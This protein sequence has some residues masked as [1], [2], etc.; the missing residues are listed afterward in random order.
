MCVTGLQ[1]IENRRPN[2]LR[3]YT[4]H[5]TASTHER[6]RSAC[7]APLT[8]TQ[9]SARFSTPG[10][11]ALPRLVPEPVPSTPVRPRIP[12]RAARAKQA[13][14]AHS[15]GDQAADEHAGL[16]DIEVPAT[17]AARERSRGRSRF[18]GGPGLQQRRA[19]PPN[20]AWWAVVDICLRWRALSSHIVSR[21]RIVASTWSACSA[22]TV[23]SCVSASDISGSGGRSSSGAAGAAASAPRRAGDASP[24]A[25]HCRRASLSIATH[26][27]SAAS[28]WRSDS[29]SFAGST[30]VC[31]ARRP[32][33]CFLLQ[34][35]E[36]FPARG[37]R[38]EGG[39]GRRECDAPGRRPDDESRACTRKRPAVSPPPRR[40]SLRR[41]ARW[42][43]TLGAAREA[44]QAARRRDSSQGPQPPPRRQRRRDPQRTRPRASG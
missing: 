23:C 2:P 41:Q 19:H 15:C 30:C 40:R 31:K 38:G 8:T 5:M 39:E 35:G 17:R 33:I 32:Q 21:R 13:R 25:V 10:A 9:P 28:R 7:V 34:H 27:C 6:P 20:A 16:V 12:S 18:A 43:G 42:P 29:F 3:Q 24:R 44:S 26:R 37:S 36:P 14:V 4:C 11:L 22:A 1:T